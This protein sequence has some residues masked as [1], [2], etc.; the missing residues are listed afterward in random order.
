MTR[1]A[2]EWRSVSFVVPYG[3]WMRPKT[4]ID[5]LELSVPEG[6]ALGLVGPN[7]AGKTT[8]IKLGAGLIRPASG[9]VFINGKPSLHSRSRICLGLLTETQYIYPHLKLYEWLTMAAG[10]S[11]LTGAD[12]NRRVCEVLEKMDLVSKAN[13]LM[14]TLSKGQT[15]RAGIAQAL[16][17]K[18]SIL[19]LDE[20][21]SGLDPLWRY[22]IQ[23][24]LLAFKAGGGTLLFSSHIL[25]DVERLSDEVALI[26]GGR[27]CCRR[28]NGLSRKPAPCE[29]LRL[30]S[31]APVSRRSRAFRRTGKPPLR[32]TGPGFFLHTRSDLRNGL[33]V[34]AAAC[35]N[36]RYRSQTGLKLSTVPGSDRIARGTI[37]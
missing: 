1:C 35:G 29:G 3:F 10:L 6:A 31:D 33:P 23:E 11:G 9:Q 28:E 24:I 17:H 32:A 20:P 34:R 30:G 21:M 36:N 8:T 5:G 26:D 19:L 37:T 14:R 4:I 18:P 7:G 25:S 12:R 15:Q 13:Q 27:I 16:I 2:L 22:R